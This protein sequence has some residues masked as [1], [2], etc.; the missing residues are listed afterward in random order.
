MLTMLVVMVMMEMEMEIE[1][2]YR[3]SWLSLSLLSLSIQGVMNACRG[4]IK[5]KRP[6]FKDKIPVPIDVYRSPRHTRRQRVRLR[7]RETEKRR[8]SSL[9]SLHPFHPILLFRDSL[10]VGTLVS[11]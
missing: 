5:E 1:T 11:C 6:G 9:L 7:G 10:S 4:G 2:W 8:R 3:R